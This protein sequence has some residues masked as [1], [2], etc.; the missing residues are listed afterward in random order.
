LAQVSLVT[1]VDMAAVYLHQLVMGG[2]AVEAAPDA[3]VALGFKGR[4]V[5]AAPILRQITIMPVA[6]AA[7][8]ALPE[9]M[10]LQGL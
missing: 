5:M 3:Q 1:A 8:L 6:A 2:L 7:A 9:L 10:L 4:A